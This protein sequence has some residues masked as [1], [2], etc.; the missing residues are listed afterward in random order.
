MDPPD[1]FKK[2]FA[3]KAEAHRRAKEAERRRST[4]TAS[5]VIIATV[6]WGGIAIATIG[7][8]LPLRHLLWVVGLIFFAA[9]TVRVF[10]KD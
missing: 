3:S 2:F 9:L 8:V 10:E 1:V 4:Q 6:I 7:D 5:L